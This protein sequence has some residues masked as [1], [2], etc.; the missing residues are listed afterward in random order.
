M[1]LSAADVDADGVVSGWDVMSAGA[2]QP[3]SS[4]TIPA[5]VNTRAIP[6]FMT[7]PPKNKKVRQP[8][9]TYRKTLTPVVAKQT[10]P[11]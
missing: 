3:P 11:P 9:L 5:R 6:F 2:P 1:V 7:D 8:K 4:R 10:K